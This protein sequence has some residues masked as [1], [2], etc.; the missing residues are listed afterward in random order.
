MSDEPKTLPRP[1][2][3]NNGTTDEPEWVPG[4]LHAWG[5]DSESYDNGVWHVPVGIV[6]DSSGRMHSV[7]VTRIS[8]AEESPDKEVTN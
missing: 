3:V 1:C 6:E 4:T 5:I 8:L 7:Y 2:W